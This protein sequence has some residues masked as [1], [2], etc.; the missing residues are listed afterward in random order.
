MLQS[1][2]RT[3]S[4]SK[5]E[6]VNADQLNNLMNGTN[7]VLVVDVRS[8]HEYER[9]GHIPGSRLLPMYALMERA[10]ELPKDQDIIFVCRSG[11]RSNVVCE[12]LARQGYSNVKNF[13]GGMI[14]WKMAGLPTQ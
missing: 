5:V 8:P 2:F 3:R 1:L 4:V 9:E 6:Q 14:A 13:S 12:Q 11:S 10:S 7:H